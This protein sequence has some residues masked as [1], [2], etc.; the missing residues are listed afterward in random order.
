MLIIS[1]THLKDD[2]LTNLDCSTSVV[3]RKYIDRDSGHLKPQAPLKLAVGMAPLD[4]EGGCRRGETEIKLRG[5][6]ELDIG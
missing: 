5:A 1:Y 6:A 2:R 3:A 4:R